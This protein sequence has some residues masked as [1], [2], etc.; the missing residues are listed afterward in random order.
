MARLIVP[1]MQLAERV[2]NYLDHLCLPYVLMPHAASRTLGEAAALTHI[3]PDRLVRAVLLQD[4]QGLFLAVLPADHLLDF[5]VLRTSCGRDCRPASPEQVAT[6]FT[7][8]SPGSVPP[9]PEPYGIPAI[10]DT[11]LAG[12][13]PIHFEAGS[14][15]CLVSMHS[16][17]FQVLHQASQWA[18][19]ARP[20]S[21]LESRDPRDFMLP[22]EMGKQHA[23]S[24]MRPVE[25]IRQTIEQVER[26]PAM[27][28][29]ANRLL[30]LLNNPRATVDDLTDVIQFDPSL[31]AQILRYA[32]SAFFGYRGKIETLHQAITR[33]L[34]FE[35]VLA[36]ALGLA[37]SRS[38]RN[39]ADGPL[40]L[41]AFWRHATHSAALAQALAAAIGPR[42]PFK[43]GLAYLAGLLHNFGFLLA[44]HLFRAEFFLLNR[45]VAANPQVPVT[46]IERRVLGVEHTQIG[47]WLMASWNMPEA[48]VV[49]C[50]EHHNEFYAGDHA[51]YAQL[52]LCVDHL[53]RAHGIGE[54]SDAVPPAGILTALG[55]DIDKAQRLTQR[56]LESREAL[57]AMARQLAA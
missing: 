54:G 27:P 39:P 14:H 13:E 19:I 49:S 4:A 12:G 47:A 33:V 20:L 5:S 34:G 16:D 9:V 32:R 42:L 24:D 37:A 21:T 6:V 41:Q 52:I 18:A 57:D 38:F 28:E 35:T 3:D 44:G 56:L 29:M 25:D 10:I 53:L 40:G 7:D 45:V 36:M 1:G 55:L 8:C 15:R 2:K 11:R 23:L 46:L 50:R 22:G 31:T 48:V 30:R 51:D 26:L 17:S 43:P